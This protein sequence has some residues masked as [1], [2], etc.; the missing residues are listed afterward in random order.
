M[1]PPVEPYPPAQIQ[2]AIAFGK[3]VA[4]GLYRADELAEG[5]VNVAVANG[6]KASLG[7]LRITLMWRLLDSAREWE[8]R[9]DRVEREIGWRLRPELEGRAPSAD[10]VRLADDINHR[11]GTP[12]APGEPRELVREHVAHHFLR[13]RTHSTMREG[14]RHAA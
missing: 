9:R 6:Y 5:L 4:W 14:L 13:T 11:F 10:L 3:W 1:S 7:G 12:L 2:A 8:L